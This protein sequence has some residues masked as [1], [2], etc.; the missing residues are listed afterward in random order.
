MISAG[1]ASGDAHAASVVSALRERCPELESF[2]MGSR[3][4]ADA[5]TDLLVDFREVAVMGYVD[6]LLNYSTLRK[7]LQL[8]KNAMHERKPDALVIV[9][10]AT[11][12]LKLADAAKEL[13]IPVLFF[14][15]PKIWA[16]RPKRVEHIRKVV[17]H[18]A[19]I[20]PFEEAVYQQAHVPANYVG[21]PLIEQ[22]NP[23][24]SVNAARRQ[25][26][27]TETTNAQPDN[28]NTLYIGLLPGSRQSELKYNLPVLLETA[29]NL[30][31]KRDEHCHFL[32]PVAPTLNKQ[33]VDE[34]TRQYKDLDIPVSYTHLTLP[35]K[36]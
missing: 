8:L 22:I 29:Q 15:G 31:E 1:E 6:V 30:S 23:P 34:H 2:G 28:K 33:T 17:T 19:L 27:Q 5:G 16:S 12:N 25:L 35:T 9:D 13:G 36:A 11:F 20:L 21:N 4:L 24:E 18:M 14:I 10:Y 26:N 3:K 7:R 32:L